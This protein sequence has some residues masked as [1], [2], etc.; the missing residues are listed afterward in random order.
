MGTFIVR[1]GATE[2]HEA[3]TWWGHCQLCGGK[4]YNDQCAGDCC[5]GPDGTAKCASC[6]HYSPISDLI[7]IKELGARDDWPPKTCPCAKCQREVRE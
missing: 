2:W 6:G 3:E 4:T 5:P 1:P 7:T